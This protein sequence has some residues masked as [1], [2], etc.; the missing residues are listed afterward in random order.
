MTLPSAPPVLTASSEQ[1]ARAQIRA[2]ALAMAQALGQDAG[3]RAMKAL[4]YPWEQKYH[5]GAFFREAKARR[6][7]F[8]LSQLENSMQ[9]GSPNFERMRDLRKFLE[10][11]QRHFA[12]EA[13]SRTHGLMGKDPTSEAYIASRVEA[14]QAQGREEAY[15]EIIEMLDKVLAPEKMEPLQS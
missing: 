1:A 10:S 7:E 11:C 6:I 2:S 12:R 5:T 9:A 8:A 4:L 14:V 15:S 13:Y 3:A